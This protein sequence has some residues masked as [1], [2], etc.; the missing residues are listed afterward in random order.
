MDDTDTVLE[1]TF[2]TEARGRLSGGGFTVSK[3]SKSSM[4]V[5]T[6]GRSVTFGTK[7]LSGRRFCLLFM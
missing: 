1:V 4:K 5:S 2:E 6:F 3:S 7:I